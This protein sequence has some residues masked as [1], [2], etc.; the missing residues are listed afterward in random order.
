VCFLLKG[1]K[2]LIEKRSVFINGTFFVF[3]RN[4]QNYKTLIFKEVYHHAKE[5]FKKSKARS[6]QKGQVWENFIRGIYNGYIICP[7]LPAG[8]GVRNYMG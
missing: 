7:A 6:K 8:F 5:Q 2:Y 1:S 4:K 3:R